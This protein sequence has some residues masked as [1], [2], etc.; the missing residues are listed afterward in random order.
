MAITQTLTLSVVA[1]GNL[2]PGS[3]VA[4][5]GVEDNRS[6]SV[7][8]STTNQVVALAITVANLQSIYISSNVTLTLKTNSSGSPQ[9]TIVITAGNPFV[10]YKNCGIPIPFAGNITTTYWT[11]ATLVN[12]NLEMRV[13]ST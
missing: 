9:E 8:A 4:T 1:G 7:P 10:W 13:L 12:A 3:F 11:N 6:V 2:L 5:G